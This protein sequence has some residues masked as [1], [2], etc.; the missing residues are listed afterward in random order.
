[1]D[2]NR[3]QWAPSGSNGFHWAPLGSNAHCRPLGPV[4][5]RWA[6]NSAVPGRGPWWAAAGE[7]SRAR[8]TG[9]SA[10]N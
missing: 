3:R 8:V 2:P 4:G 1:M 9:E 10:R 5:A 6:G 7:A